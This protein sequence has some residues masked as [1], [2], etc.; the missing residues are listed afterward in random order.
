MIALGDAVLY[1]L[2][3]GVWSEWDVMK[4]F[5][6][7]NL[8]VL[9]ACAGVHELSK[10]WKRHS[11]EGKACRTPDT[12]LIQRAPA[13]QFPGSLEFLQRRLSGASRIYKEVGKRRRRLGTCEGDW[14][15]KCMGEANKV[16][17]PCLV[18]FIRNSFR[19]PFCAY[20]RRALKTQH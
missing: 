15:V 19:G 9:D 18:F 10:P 6:K 17:L 3:D 7:A 11:I 8:L 5:K 16:G 14:Q 12:K 1:V 20:C 4:K 13:L 2:N